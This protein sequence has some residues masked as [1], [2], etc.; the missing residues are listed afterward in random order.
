MNCCQAVAMAYAEELPLGE[1]VIMRLCAGFG[2]GMGTMDGTCGAL[3]GAIMVSSLKST[4]KAG[5]MAMSRKI[6]PRFRELCGSIVCR[7][8]KGMDTGN[9]LC[10]CVDCVRNAVRALEEALK[11]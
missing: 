1:E 4:D 2:A 11:E 9:V 6:L 5:A 10:P 8:L 3:V 7:E